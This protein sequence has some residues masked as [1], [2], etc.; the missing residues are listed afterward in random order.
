MLFAGQWTR[1]TPIDTAGL[2][3]T[4]A[5]FEGKKAPVMPYMLHFRAN[6]AAS[7]IFTLGNLVSI[8]SGF[9]NPDPSAPRAPKHPESR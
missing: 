7:L 8:E 6:Q 4:P 3:F 2:E 9:C 1:F 5:A